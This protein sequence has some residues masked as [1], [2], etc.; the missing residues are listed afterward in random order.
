[1]MPDMTGMELHAWLATHHPDLADRVVFMTGGVFTTRAAEYLA[2][3]DNP[4][5]NK[6]FEAD[7]LASVVAALV[8]RAR[9]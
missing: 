8:S 5:V 3:V 6:P 7:E 4:R 9:P 2:S 1:M